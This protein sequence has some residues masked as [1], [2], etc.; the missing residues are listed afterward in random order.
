ME[1]DEIMIQKS[2][3][4][5]LLVLIQAYIL[6]GLVVFGLIYST[7]PSGFIFSLEVSFQILCHLF[8]G[9]VIWIF[10]SWYITNKRL[11]DP[12]LLFLLSAILFNGGQIILEV[13]RLNEN[14]FLD[15]RFP[16]SESLQV[17]Y[18]VILS[19]SAVHLGAMC[20][21]IDLPKKYASQLSGS[22][23]NNSAI[24]LWSRPDTKQYFKSGITL[25]DP[26]K[27]IKPISQNTA[28]FLGQIFLYL[29][30]I[31]VLATVAGAVQL[32]KSGGYGSLFEQQAVTGF[33][34]SVG[35]MSDFIFPGVFLII[36]G[37]ERKP[38]L[39][40]FAAIYLIGYTFA[41]FTIGS[42]GAAVMPLLSMLW[43][44]DSVVRPIP[45]TLLAAVAAIL[46]FIVF[47]VIGATRNEI[48]GVDLFSIEFL[49][50]T[51]TSVNNPLVASISEMGFSAT[52]IGWTMELVPKVRPFDLGMSFLVSIFTLIP[53]IFTSDRHPALTMSGYDTPDNWLV[54]IIDPAFASQG[55]GLGFSFIAEAYL[56]FGWFGI[57][58]LGLIGFLFAKFTQWA[59]Q[60][61]DPV[62][63][64]IIAI[65][66]SFF[67]IYPRASS[68]LVIRPLIWYCLFPY[69]WMQRI[70][71]V[72]RKKEK[73]QEQDI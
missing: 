9:L 44:W 17:V 57:V 24:E 48:A 37:G 12:Y 7:N 61:R 67:L 15:N 56:N 4:N 26:S 21:V 51:L 11:F 3:N 13:F 10:A 6:I 32:A 63:M 31:P 46:L 45:R 68:Q 54:G 16:L 41:K 18:I 58:I 38:S 55:G 73:E 2:R 52:P 35:V 71:K 47:P 59:V 50:K 22:S 53:N 25:Y 5:W 72:N 36:A 27:I 1:R 43:L 28:L 60:D 66:V 34:A 65:F 8:V 39:R 29:S 30:I 49:T 64:A 20:T 42:R 19:L 14:G 23:Y 33:A 69:L 40:I 70:D 62:K